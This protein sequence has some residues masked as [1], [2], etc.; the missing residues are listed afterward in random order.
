VAQLEAKLAQKSR[1]L[2]RAEEEV[3]KLTKRCADLVTREL[4]SGMCSLLSSKPH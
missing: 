4:K 3:I 2:H 1:E